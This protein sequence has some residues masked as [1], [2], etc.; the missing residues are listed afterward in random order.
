MSELW[1]HQKKAVERAR[2]VNHLALLH[3]TGVGKTCTMINILAE[4]QELRG[5]Q[6]TL[7]FAPLSVCRQW[8]QEIEKFWIGPHPPILVLVGTGKQRCMNLSRYS[9]QQQSLL[10]ITNYESCR[11]QSFYELLLKWKPQV[12]VCDE[13]HRLKDPQSLQSKKIFPLAQGAKRRFILTGTPVLNSM[14]DL[15]G[16]Y[17]IL[18]PG[19]FGMNF[20]VFRSKYFYDKNSG[21]SQ[22]T[23]FPDWRPKPGADL[24]MSQVLSKSSVQAKKHECLDLPPLHEIPVPVEMSLEQSRVYLEMERDAVAVLK[25]QVHIAPFAMVK[26]IRLQQLLCGFITDDQEVVTHL[27]EVPRLTALRDLIDSI[28]QTEK[29]IIWTNFRPTYQTIGDVCKA[30]GR[31]HSYLIGG[32]SEK[33]KQ[34]SIENFRKGSTQILISNPAAGGTGINLTEAA[35]SIYYSRGYSLEHSEQSKAR[36][37]RGG[38][39]RHS[40]ITHYHLYCPKSLDGVITMALLSKQNIGDSILSYAKQLSE[41]RH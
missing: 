5:P 34:E 31:S 29:I 40:K 4:D 39:D 25:D 7:I 30:L 9:V 11:I 16:Q 27:A 8:A 14:M 17:K 21:M 2:E 3:E 12:L 18:D 1:E 26:L 6:R 41:I 38:S 37:F 20:F 28:P 33:E 13:S 35:Y 22:Q 36:N 32:Q 23:H 10:A 24:E 19:H 15:Y